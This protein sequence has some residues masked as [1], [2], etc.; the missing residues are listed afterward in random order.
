MEDKNEKL[1]E[2]EAVE[3]IKET[4]Q[5]PS[6]EEQEGEAAMHDVR[7]VSPAVL[8]F[9][10][11][12]R[13]KLSVIGL[14]MFVLLFLFVFV[15]PTTVGW[16]ETEV[17]RS[18]GQTTYTQYTTEFVGADG[19]TY[20]VVQLNSYTPQIN[21]FAPVFSYG[22]NADGEEVMHILGTDR[23]GMDI[24]A[25]LMYGGRISLTISFLAVILNTL[26][27]IVMG[28]LAGYFGKWVDMVIM[29]IV[30]VINCVPTLPI[31]LIF[32]AILDAYK[33]D[34][35]FLYTYRIYIIMGLLTLISWTGTARLVRGQILFLRE[36]EY[37]VA[38]DALGM[39]PAR[40]I[41][42][43]LVINVMPQLIVS[44][45]LSLGSMILY[46]ATLGYLDLGVPIPYAS[47]GNMINAAKDTDVLQYY[48]NVWLPSGICI[49][50]AVLAF[51][52]IGDGLR[53]ALDPKMK[54]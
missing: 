38:A 25:R 46:E 17:D 50:M 35:P 20:T 21:V 47:W 6:P 24:M 15:G 41:F 52:F 49:I 13:S 4:Q 31:M 51:N 36:Q 9:K 8:V 37:M 11:F 42:R 16:G 39:S 10:R 34:Y 5:A 2:L 30:D 18:G 43:H 45:T 23:S 19:E 26:L 54:R 3:E 1:E 22:T 48:A 40:K 32:S 44:M 53:D 12:F 7:I 28:G 14:V 33:A 29:R 27:G